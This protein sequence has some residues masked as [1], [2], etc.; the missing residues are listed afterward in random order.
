MTYGKSQA[1]DARVT[2]NNK[3][4]FLLSRLI[5]NTP[6]PDTP[7]YRA[8]LTTTPIVSFAIVI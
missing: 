3:D 2:Q 4:A 1:E 5:L 7:N 6:T 8:I